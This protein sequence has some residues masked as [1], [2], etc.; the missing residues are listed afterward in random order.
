MSGITGGGGHRVDVI[1][2]GRPSSRTWLHSPTGQGQSGHNHSETL[3][4][5]VSLRVR[6]LLPENKHICSFRPLE[7]LAAYT[8]SAPSLK[9]TRR[10]KRQPL[11]ALAAFDAAK[12]TASRVHWRIKPQVSNGPP[13]TPWSQHN[14]LL[15]STSPPPHHA[16]PY[17]SPSLGVQRCQHVFSSS[18]RETA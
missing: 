8:V 12:P 7:N 15:R 14:V 1:T 5:P 6:L 18:L 10:P 13:Q 2:D 3:P 16:P 11:R 17:P 4:G 9:H